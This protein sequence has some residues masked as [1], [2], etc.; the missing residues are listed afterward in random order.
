[1]REKDKKEVKKRNCVVIMREIKIERERERERKK[2][3]ERVR[4]R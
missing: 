4:E 2:R 1:M 3:R